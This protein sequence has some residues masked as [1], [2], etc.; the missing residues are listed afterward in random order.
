MADIHVGLGPATRDG[1]GT[2]VVY[3]HFPT[4]VAYKEKIVAA[5]GAQTPSAPEVDETEAASFAA[6]DTR[7][8][9]RSVPINFTDA[10]AFAT[11]RTTARAGWTAVRDEEQNK[12]RNACQY[13]GTTWARSVSS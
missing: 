6:G 13:Y 10:N 5:Y 12:L 1:D 9:V 7:E 3:Y 8:A 4:P 11:A 2:L